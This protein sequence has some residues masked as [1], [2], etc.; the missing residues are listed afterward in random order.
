MH[1]VCH[2]RMSA[3]Q[4]ASRNVLRNASESLHA[5][6]PDRSRPL[7]SDAHLS[8]PFHSACRCKEPGCG[9]VGTIRWGSQVNVG[10]KRMV[11]TADSASRDRLRPRSEAEVV[12]WGGGV[13]DPAGDPP[14]P[15]CGCEAR[16]TTRR[17]RLSP[18]PVALATLRP[19]T[20]SRRRHRWTA[21]ADGAKQR[22]SRLSPVHFSRGRTL[23][24]G[25]FGM[26]WRACE[27]A[28]ESSMK[29]VAKWP[30]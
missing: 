4:S 16:Q 15:D 24:R 18:F 17:V 28:G 2:S 14:A 9:R 13:A 8:V 30:K 11:E 22:H 19:D 10:R 26:D 25:T 20:W 23:G 29:R 6:A 1:S 3:C 21:P 5:T 7:G 27:P 12:Q